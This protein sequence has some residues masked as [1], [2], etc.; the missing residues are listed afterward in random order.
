MMNVLQN[1]AMM[2]IMQNVKILELFWISIHYKKLED[3][4]NIFWVFKT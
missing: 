3:K 2:V 1:Y 4:I